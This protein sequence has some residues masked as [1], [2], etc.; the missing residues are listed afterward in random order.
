M[1]ADRPQNVCR[2]GRTAGRFNSHRS[3]GKVSEED[4][5]LQ[6]RVL[7]PHRKVRQTRG[8]VPGPRRDG[9]HPVGWRYVHMVINSPTLLLLGGLSFHESTLKTLEVAGRSLAAG[10]Q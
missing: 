1:A 4:R 5:A 6:P 9:R 3:T 2:T 8:S 10:F 7:R